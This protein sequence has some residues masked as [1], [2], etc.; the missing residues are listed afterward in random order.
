MGPD[1]TP[2]K[3]YG[4]KDDPYDMEKDI[5]EALK[6]RPQDETCVTETKE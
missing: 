2:L 4:S 5:I 3:R 1:G 6:T